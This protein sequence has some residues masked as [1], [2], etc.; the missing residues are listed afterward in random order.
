MML[1]AAQVIDRGKVVDPFASAQMADGVMWHGPV[2]RC[3]CRSFAIYRN[4]PVEVV[5]R[6]GAWQYPASTALADAIHDAKLAP[7]RKFQVEHERG[8]RWVW[9]NG[10]G[11]CVSAHKNDRGKLYDVRV[12]AE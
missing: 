9:V 3:D 10:R 4:G 2:W 6:E 7:G 11:L 1:T 8:P 5:Y 12:E